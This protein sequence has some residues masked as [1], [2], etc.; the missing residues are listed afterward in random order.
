MSIS[1]E[2]KYLEDEVA[3]L[4]ADKEHLKNLLI[5][6]NTNYRAHLAKRDQ[7]LVDAA[8]ALDAAERKIAEQDVLIEL[9]TEELARF[10]L[11]RDMMNEARY[12]VSP[13]K[14]SPLEGDRPL[15]RLEVN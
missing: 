5:D 1:E 10:R 8:A 9:K 6:Q 11:A 15:A 13:L 3:D 12:G 2:V 4:R 14:P 7:Q